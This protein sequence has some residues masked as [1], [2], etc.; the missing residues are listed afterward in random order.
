MDTSPQLTSRNSAQSWIRALSRLAVLK[1]DNTLTLACLL[2][3]VAAIQPDAEA[4]T[5]ELHSVTFA[6]MLHLINSYATYASRQS[7][8][9]GD[10]VG[11]L[12]DNCVQYG[13]IWIG[14]NR[15][16]VKVALLNTHLA[17]EA[18]VHCIEAVKPSVLIYGSRFE[19]VVKAIQPSLSEPVALWS[20][21]PKEP[22]AC[23][24]AA[25]N[26]SETQSLSS[27][28]EKLRPSQDST[29][30]YIYTSGTSGL[31]KAAEISHHRV[32]QWA[33][34]FCGIMN[35]KA[36]DRMYNCLPLYHSV[37]GVVAL[38]ATLVG[39]GTVVLRRKFSATDFWADVQRERCTLFQYIGE[40]CRYLI[41]MPPSPSDGEHQLR[42]CCGNGLRADVWSGFKDRFKIPSILEY[43]A[44]TE[45]TF[46]LYNC[47][48]KVGS[49]G[50][51]P[52]FLQQTLRVELIQHDS[53]TATPTR[54][55]AGHCVRVEVNQP[56]EAIGLVSNSGSSR[57]TRFEGYTDAAASEKKLLR[58]VF[59]IGD[60]WYRT[61][62]L[63]RRD[64][65]GFFYFV[66]RVGDTF[67]WKGENVSTAEVELAIQ[68]TAGVL[69]AV[70]YGVTV[71][72]SDGRA[73][74]AALQVG[75]D[76]SLGVLVSSLDG[77]LPAYARP[78]FLRLIEQFE[79]T[80]TFKTKKGHLQDE[81]FDRVIGDDAVYLFDN[82]THTYALLD[83]QRKALL[84]SGAIRL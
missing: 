16:G 75:P 65:Q 29:A 83:E 67:R 22:M 53:L 20:D 10:V 66:D 51:I 73:G 18:L 28:A 33:L 2:E 61:G 63:M 21:G 81:G 45:G 48:E 35:V 31:P 72:R 56:G 12:M 50:R 46:S 27:F 5:D 4:L 58:N 49:I 60:C 79:V 19:A 23:S 1:E 57:M 76:F 77:S 54:D 42:L 59:E 55:S 40:L 37:G 47:E 62:D 7:L 26:A 25:Y 30:L 13:A 32:M 44:A 9:S 8:K 71:P 14:L 84:Y 69:A 24:I 82:Q 17:N 36:T 68:K 39:G 43:Y 74:M 38:G 78:V 41:N 34:W 70:V 52:P 15:L 11:L 6:Q 64:E 80:G 3:R